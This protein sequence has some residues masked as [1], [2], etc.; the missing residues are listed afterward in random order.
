MVSFLNTEIRFPD[1]E[2][3]MSAI[4]RM[5]ITAGI[6]ICHELAP[7]HHEVIKKLSLPQS[8]SYNRSPMDTIKV[9]FEEWL[10]RRT[11]L[12]PTWEEMLAFMRVIGMNLLAVL[13]EKYF[14]GE[15]ALFQTYLL[16]TPHSLHA[17]RVRLLSLQQP[18]ND[19]SIHLLT[20]KLA[21]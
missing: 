15:Q 2:F 5:K 20:C 17:A 10:A 11:P 9:V 12:L 1:G 14:F 8:L 16:T 21:L 3:S 4:A 19:A 18:G 7:K 13:I 6:D